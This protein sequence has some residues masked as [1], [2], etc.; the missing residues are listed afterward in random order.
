MNT[1]ANKNSPRFRAQYVQHDI[2]IDGKK[3]ENIEDFSF[4]TDY[5]NISYPEGSGFMRS[6]C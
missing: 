2:S 3:V 4:T 1:G 5:F 6:H